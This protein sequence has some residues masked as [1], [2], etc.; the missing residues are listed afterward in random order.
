MANQ[1]RKN[2]RILSSAPTNAP[3]PKTPRT[4]A[5]ARLLWRISQEDVQG[6]A[7]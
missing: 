3:L 1:P 4:V 7:A 2:K 6:K 5:L